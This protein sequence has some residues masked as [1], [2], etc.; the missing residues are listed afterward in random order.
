MNWTEEQLKA[1]NFRKNN[2]LVSAA[3]GSGKTAVLVERIIKIILEDGVSLENM[4]IVTFTNAAASEMRE[5]ILKSLTL[6]FNDVDDKEFLRKQ[7]NVVNNAFIM[8]MHSFCLEVVRKNYFKIDIDPNFKIGDSTDLMMMLSESIDEIFENEYELRNEEFISLVESYSS[9][10]DD[11][12]LKNI[13]LKIYRFIKSKANPFE[14]LYEVVKFYDIDKENFEN[15]I[16]VKELK[17]NIKYT[18]LSSKELLFEAIEIAGS[19]FGP[20]DYLETLIDDNSNLESLIEFSNTSYDEFIDYIS[21]LEFKR[22][23]SISKKKKEFVD[24]EFIDKVKSLRKLYK[25]SLTKLKKSINGKKSD[26]IIKMLSLMKNN[27]KYLSNLIY[28]IELKYLEKKK[29]K[30]I[31]DFNDLEH[32]AIEILKDRNIRNYYKNKFEHIVLDEYQDSNIVQETIINY[33]K[34]ENNLFLVGDVKQSI[35]KFRLADSDLFLQKYKNYDGNKG[36]RIDLNKN[37]RSRKEILDG[38]N[39]LFKNLMLEEI[40]GLNYTKDEFL[41]AGMK[42]EENYDPNIDVDIINLSLNKNAENTDIDEVS[43]LIEE[44]KNLEIEAMYIAQ[45]IK[46]IL[47]KKVYIAKKNEYKN[48]EYKDIV[49]LL[50]ATKGKS[51]VFAQIFNDF[52]IPLFS[53]TPISYFEST[54]VKIFINLLKLI[55]N[56]NQDIPLISVL[57]SP[58]VGLNAE[59]LIKIRL[60]DK[61]EKFYKNFYNYTGDKILEQKINKFREELDNYI[62]SSKYMKLD[63]FLWN[64]MIESGYY[65]Y[66]IAMVDGKKREYNL[67]LLVEKASYFEKTTASSIFSFINYIEKLKKTSSDFQGAIMPSES[68]NVVRLMSIHKSKG[69]EFPVVI[70][71]N[72]SKKINFMD[73]NSNLLLD[74]NLGIGLRY[75]DYVNRYYKQSLPQI[76]IKHVLKKSLIA[77]E[78]RILYVALTRAVDKLIIVASVKDTEKSIQNWKKR[79]TSYNILE[80]KSYIDWIMMVLLSESESFDLGDMVIEKDDVKWNLKFINSFEIVSKTLKDDEKKLNYKEILKN[81]KFEFDEEKFSKI[82]NRLNYKYKSNIMIPSKLTATDIK[83]INNKNYEEVIHKKIALKD[84]MEFLKDKKLSATSIGTMYHKIFQHID[85]NKDI[86]SKIIINRLIQ[87]NLLD[88]DNLQ[89]IDINK[90]NKF[91]NSKIFFRIKNSEKYFKEIPFVYKKIIEDNDVLIQG[92]IDLYFIEDNNIVLLDYKSDKIVKEINYYKKIYKPQIDV[93]A[94]A[95]EKST[96][97]KVTERYIYFID[98]NTLEKI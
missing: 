2:I 43:D 36:I 33:I 63:D 64:L 59:D 19:E 30:N 4:L 9:N 46:S 51:E 18:L 23:K 1:I 71:A 79:V 58:I 77:E 16:W 84:G 40:G 45:K 69:L 89:Y 29:E 37:F 66:T 50:R 73:L 92:I 31:V 68:E 6:K 8:T 3:A 52:S 48:I 56:K 74:K 97:F 94:E 95:L 32:F 14:W 10:R 5:R 67:K 27:I 13:V 61:D 81:L 17:E 87:K 85:F 70:L 28:K 75:T 60:Y 76:A 39:V 24:I 42:F 96:K 12:E 83:K 47:G 53:D 38:V 15:H 62:Y 49:I 80:T 93:Y 41:N 90:I 44:L 78:L 65:Y 54:E 11:A 34:R 22:L 82:N 72:A 20:D 86:D 35:Y 7:I 21:K 57:H 91:I 26:N 88:K 98:N 55:D 25:E